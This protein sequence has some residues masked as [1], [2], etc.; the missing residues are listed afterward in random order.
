MKLGIDY[1]YDV[2]GIELAESDWSRIKAGSPVELAGQGFSIEGRMDQDF[3]HFNQ[4][5]RGTLSIFCSRG[6]QIYH[7][8]VADLM[9]V[10]D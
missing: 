8:I 7:G 6:H 4:E 10:K 1:G 5:S 2:H 3:W 9:V